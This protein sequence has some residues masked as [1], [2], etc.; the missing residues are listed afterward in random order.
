MLRKIYS[1]S[2]NTHQLEFFRRRIWF[3][4][5]LRLHCLARGPRSLPTSVRVSL[6]RPQ[7][8]SL[9]RSSLE[10]KCQPMAS[11]QQ[12]VVLCRLPVATCQPVPPCQPTLPYQPILQTTETLLKHVRVN[13]VN[14]V[15]IGR[16]IYYEHLCFDSSLS[17]RIS[18]FKIL[19][20]TFMPFHY[21]IL[22]KHQELRILRQF[23]SQYHYKF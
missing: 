14:N 8:T 11:C 4:R 3:L 15:W 21:E 6:C 5:R 2:I 23:S 7:A 12:P 17:R 19:F 18:F 22:M 1:A 13:K 9:T 10:K 16:S 20:L